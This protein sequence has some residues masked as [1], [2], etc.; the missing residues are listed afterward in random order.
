MQ[1]LQG[2]ARS[3]NG[4]YRSG[5][6]PRQIAKRVRKQPAFQPRR[7]PSAAR[8]LAA[9]RH[10]PFLLALCFAVCF[11][12]AWS[13]HL[14]SSETTPASAASPLP[15]YFFGFTPD[16]GGADD[17]TLSAYYKHIKRGGARWVRFGVYW[18]YI[19]KTKGSYTW[20]STDRF[21]AAAACSGLVALPMFIGSPRWAS[22]R[23]STIA[24]PTRT[25]LPEFQTMIRRVIARYGRGGSYW[26]QGHHCLN[27]RAPVPASPAHSW[28]VWNEPNAMNYYGDRQ[29]TAR[30]YGRLLT[31]ADNAMNTSV[32]PDAN[33]VLGGMTGSG[34]PDFLRALYNAVPNLN[35]HVDIFDLHAYATT[36]QHSLDL[37]RAF[38]HT[39]NAHGARAKR[40]WVSEVAWS[41]CKQSG[42]GY[43]AKCRN[44]ALA[45]NEAGQRYYLTRMYNKLINNA[46]ALRLRRVAWYSWKDPSLS[47][48]TCRF[49][50]GSGLFHRDGSRKPAWSAYVNLAGGQM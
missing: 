39:A 14:T 30:G 15:K 1:R 6:R 19:E 42:Y 21:F 38:R 4:I 31:A 33:T 8:G 35:S 46:S 37:L 32:N 34:A 29:A 50:Y 7:E 16:F 9:P 12:V 20:H 27:S 13:G 28:Q 2:V 36:P 17:A 23:S 49:C 22:G 41:S 10:R 25:H 26:K 48:A 11:A 18:W 5:F 44:N 45:Q 3:A 43:P 40:L 47:R 24:P